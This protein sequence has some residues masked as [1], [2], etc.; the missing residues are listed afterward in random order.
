VSERP[1]S[2]GRAPEPLTRIGLVMA[3]FWGFAMLIATSIGSKAPT[4]LQYLELLSP[5]LL[6]IAAVVGARS[7]FRRG[8]RNLGT[9]AALA[10]VAI[11]PFAL[12]LVN[13]L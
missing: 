12:W 3:M 10:S 6:T 8:S 2:R 11:V 13:R 9:I 7:L 1:D 4:G 5:S